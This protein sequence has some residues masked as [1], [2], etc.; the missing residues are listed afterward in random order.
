MKIPATRV[1]QVIYSFDRGDMP[2]FAGQQ[3]DIFI[4]APENSKRQ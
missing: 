2:I 4:D 1:L 3:I